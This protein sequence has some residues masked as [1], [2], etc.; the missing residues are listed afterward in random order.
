MN[1]YNYI[2]IMTKQPKP[3]GS[4][5]PAVDPRVRFQDPEVKPYRV[6]GMKP[7]PVTLSVTWNVSPVE[8]IPLH[9]QFPGLNSGD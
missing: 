7:L 6:P 2:I 4:L 5:L 8:D 9:V 3:D 1:L